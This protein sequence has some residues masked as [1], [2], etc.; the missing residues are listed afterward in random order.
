M[1]GR[2]HEKGIWTKQPNSCTIGFENKE[3][4]NESGVEDGGLRIYIYT[5]SGD[6]LL[7]APEHHIKEDVET[8]ASETKDAIGIQKTNYAKNTAD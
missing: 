5:P 3:I 2:S 8:S 4:L 1:L 7:L 6:N